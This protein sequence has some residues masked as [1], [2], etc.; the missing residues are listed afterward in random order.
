[1][2]FIIYI[3]KHMTAKEKLKNCGHLQKEGT[4]EN[5][6]TQRNMNISKSVPNKPNSQCNKANE[7][8]APEIDEIRDGE[9]NIKYCDIKC[10]DQFLSKNWEQIIDGVGD[11]GTLKEMFDSKGD[12]GR[13]ST[14]WSFM[15]YPKKKMVQLYLQIVLD[16]I[17][18][19]NSLSAITKLMTTL[20]TYFKFDLSFTTYKYMILYCISVY[21]AVYEMVYDFIQSAKCSWLFDA[22][23]FGFHKTSS[24]FVKA[25]NYGDTRVIYLG[26]TNCHQGIGSIFYSYIVNG[27]EIDDLDNATGVVCLYV[28]LCV[29]IWVFICVFIWVYSW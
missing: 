28:Y 16:N 11:L 22:N 6:T 10:Y 15:T 5:I 2:L 19:L 13:L 26:N 14:F 20:S 17:Q 12:E 18:N 8:S 25:S 24:F 3:V 7:P 9:Y 23:K 21:V 1:M 4:Q 29:F 27:W